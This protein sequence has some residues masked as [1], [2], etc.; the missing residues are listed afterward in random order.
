MATKLA[1]ATSLSLRESFALPL[2]AET[3]KLPPIAEQ[4]GNT[5]E[6]VVKMRELP[7]GSRPQSKEFN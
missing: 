6:A 1:R 2:R 7:T 5:T 4:L 3:T